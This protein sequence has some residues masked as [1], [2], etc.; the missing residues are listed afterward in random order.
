MNANMEQYSNYK[1]LKDE[2]LIIEYYYGEV[3]TD[4]ILDMKKMLMSDKN[5]NENFNSILDFRDS[6]LNIDSKG[7]EKIVKFIRNI[8]CHSKRKIAL[9]TH[10]PE[11][12]VI[13]TLFAN[14]VNDANDANLPMQYKIF[15]TLRATTTWITN[16]NYSKKIN[17]INCDKK[18]KLVVKT[19]DKL[20]I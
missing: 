15:S 4:V 18:F 13:T 8:M 6:V 9:L 7:I 10:T 5:F 20:R 11:H 16:C 3:T 19:I 12:V 14:D 1:I 17:K 2:N